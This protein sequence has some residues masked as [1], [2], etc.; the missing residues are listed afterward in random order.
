MH[1][2]RDLRFADIFLRLGT[3][4]VAWMVLYA[5]LVWLAALRAMGCG[6][7]GAEMHQL[8]LAM[9]IISCPVVFL[10]RAT[11]TM[12]EV[13][14]LLRWLGVPLLILMPF[15][16]L[17]AWDVFS[18]AN[19]RSLSICTNSTAQPWEQLWAPMQFTAVVIIASMLIR[20]LKVHTT[21]NNKG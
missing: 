2:D 15:G 8:V 1:R 17:S 18:R 11:S 20:V 14:S 16:L 5:Y 7:D 21:E 19:G 9:S 10:T 13:H 12:P 6:A 3:S 4:L